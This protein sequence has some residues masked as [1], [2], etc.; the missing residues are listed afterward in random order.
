MK[1]NRAEHVGRPD[2]PVVRARINPACMASYVFRLNRSVPTNWIALLH[3][4]RPSR[5]IVASH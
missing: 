5:R 4:S 2:E 3:H 1:A